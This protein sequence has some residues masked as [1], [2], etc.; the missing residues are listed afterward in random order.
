M[1]DKMKKF[2][3][4]FNYFSDMI[5]AIM[6]V[7]WVISIFYS[8]IIVW[9]DTAMLYCLTDTV[10]KPMEAGVI[11][12]LIRC[13]VQHGV[14]IAKTGETLPPDFYDVKENEFMDDD[15]IIREDLEDTGLNNDS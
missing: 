10:S 12:F 7:I 6:V 1:S 8:F 14:N 2:T 9:K 13:A 11:A 5:I 4:M 3:K 15:K